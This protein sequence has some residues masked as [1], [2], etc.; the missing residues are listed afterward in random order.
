[1]GSFA[2]KIPMIFIRVSLRAF[3]ATL[4]TGFKIGAIGRNITGFVALL[5]AWF[6]LARGFLEHRFV[7]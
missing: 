4:F 6:N 2:V 7:P 5:A 3:V 1:M